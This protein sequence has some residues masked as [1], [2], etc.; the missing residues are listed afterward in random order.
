MNKKI[1]LLGLLVSFS[2][3]PSFAQ[4]NCD[5][6]CLTKG[7]KNAASAMK[8]GM[9]IKLPTPSAFT[10][11]TMDSLKK[12]HQNAEKIV[13]MGRIYQNEV[14]SV[15]LPNETFASHL[16][17]VWENGRVYYYLSNEYKR[18]NWDSSQF[19]GVEF[20]GTHE[21]SS[22]K[23]VEEYINLL[24]GKIEQL[25]SEM[26]SFSLNENYLKFLLNSPTDFL[27]IKR[28]VNV[29]KDGAYVLEDINKQE[30]TGYVELEF[31]NG[32][33]EKKNFTCIPAG[34]SLDEEHTVTNDDFLVSVFSPLKI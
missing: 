4:K 33:R 13:S 15:S 28:I 5:R 2:F 12:K 29:H 7:I 24:R 19:N 22:S 18:Q 27:N 21:V 20:L 10:H 1:L 23:S 16:Y 32:T 30:Y 11:E 34:A 26:K 25:R 3:S 9:L 8:R 17:I 31:V 14:T 6:D